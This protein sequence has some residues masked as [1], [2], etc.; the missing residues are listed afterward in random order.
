MN[1]RVKL[2]SW[3]LASL[4]VLLAT[5]VFGAPVASAKIVHEEV[6]S[7]EVEGFA[8]DI[9]A[10]RSGGPSNGDVYTADYPANAVVKFSSTGT[11][12]ATITGTETPAGSFGFVNFNTFTFSGIAIDSSGSVNKGDLYAAD[13][14]HNVV[15]KFDQTGKF[16]C[17]ITA[18]TPVSSEEQEHECNG[19]AGSAPTA[20]SFEPVAA[21][22]NGAGDLF[23]ADA[24][25]KAVDEFGPK[26]EFIKEITGPD[27]TEPTKLALAPSGALYIA[28]G[29]NIFS[30]GS[31]VVKDSGGTFAVV[32]SSE[33][34]G[35]AVDPT[36]EYLYA[37]DNSAE[38]AGV[39]RIDEY[40]P[41]GLLLGTFIS[42]GYHNAGTLAVGA[43]G[44]VYDAARES[45]TIFGPDI[46]VPTVTVAAATGV[47]ETT[48]TFHGEVSPDSA[49]GGTEVLKCE[50]EYVT[51]AQFEASQF[52]KPA[53]AECAPATPYAS[54][55]SVS[56]TISGLAPSTTYHY[57]LA[58]ASANKHVSYSEAPAE[59]T[60]ATPGPPTIAGET[61]SGITRT[62]ATLEAQVN[63]NGHDTHYEFQYGETESYGESVPIAAPENIG[64]GQAPVPV[65]QQIA[66]LKIGTTYHYRVVAENARG[67]VTGT[68]HTV[69]TVPVAGV[70][71]Q[72]VLAGPHT[73]TI[74]ARIDPKMGLPSLNGTTTCV[75]QY[76]TE[77]E[78]AASGFT[79]AS[80]LPCTP[81]SIESA[82]EGENVI[83][84]L[85]GLALDTVYDYRFVTVNEAGE[86]TV[87]GTLATFGLVP[88][89]EAGMFDTTGA[90]Y[91]QAG[92]HPYELTTNITFNSTTDGSSF[93]PASGSLKDVR[94][95]LPMGLVGNPT[96]AAK[97][98]VLIADR[99]RAPQCGPGTQVGVMHVFL[100]DGSGS[101]LDH[102]LPL[103]NVVPGKGVAAEFASSEIAAGLNATIVARVRTG[104]GYGVS[105]DSLNIPIIGTVRK[106]SVTIWG[107]PGDPAHNPQRICGCGSGESLKAFLRA[108]TSCPG[109]NLTTNVLADSYNAP[110]EFAEAHAEMPGTTNC[111]VLPF[112]PSLSVQP[113]SSAADS[114]TGL[115]FDLH[116]PQNNDP[117]GVS[118]ADLKNA[119]VTFPAGLSVNPSAADGLGACSEGQVGFTGFAELNKAS[120]PGVQTAQFTPG[121]AQCPDSSKLGDVELDTPL[122]G[123][124]L[125]GSLYLA[126]QGANPFGSMIAVYLTVDD[127]VSG[128]I[129][130][131]PGLVQ[132]NPQTGQLT[133]TFEQNPQLPFEDLKV[134][135]FG[136]SSG[137][138]ASLTTPFTCGS[139]AT[140]TALR[141]WSS[142]EGKD[143]TPS[144]PPFQI[145]EAPGGGA[146]ASSEGQTPNKPGFQAGTASPIGG[147]YSPFVLT[148]TREDGSQRF[149]SLNVT[150]P[151]GLTGKIA[152]I[153]QCPQADIEKAQ[154]RSHEGEGASE[155]S[156]PSCPSGSEVG[157]VHVGAGSGAPFYV[158]GRAYFA[159]GYEG[160]PFSLVIV[161]P[162]VAG[163]FD[164]GTVV[165]RAGLFIDPSTAQVTVKSDPFPSILDGIPLDIRSVAVDMSRPGFTLNPTSC[166][167]MA[168]TGE[169]TSTAG[170]TAG[171][172]DRFQA[173]G[174]TNL[175][176]SPSFTA[177]TQG[178]A[179]RA[180]GAS[181]VVKVDPLPGQANIAK[182]DLQLPKQLPSRLK[183]LQKA[184]TQAQFAANPAGCPEG[185]DIGRAVVHTPILNSPLAGPVYLVAHG[186]AA[187][188]DVEMVL[189]GEGVVIVL[190][191]QTQIKN[192]VTYSHFDAV[193]DAPI[194]S[195]EAVL[196]E[197]P[198]SV[199]G[200][201]IPAS[202]K[203]S[204]CGQSMRMP[205]TI[206]GQNGAVVTQNTRIGI[207]G[208][209]LTRPKVVKKALTR[210]QKLKAALKACRK[211]DRGKA[212]RRKRETCEKAGR[213]K[214]GPVKKANKS[215]GKKK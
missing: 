59:E 21:A 201:N 162:A 115:H 141:P 110:G 175:P 60:F 32:D 45:V 166:D 104:E 152:G 149:G 2:H 7:F 137:S 91:T 49:H 206:T 61:A 163:P 140:S 70:Q 126:R 55:Q 207:T 180:D 130:K 139:Y 89:V 202:A 114:P 183:T 12:L 109:G 143:E 35:V 203:F 144:S 215:H 138:R 118:T 174:C 133:A 14:E 8:L 52:A 204:L 81:A 39:G 75:F 77:A 54:A 100:E 120:E 9:A 25:H 148:L 210:A 98:T 194:S 200:T 159:G 122:L 10:D 58:A 79:A 96:A 190:D 101:L 136:G 199:F 124:P 127:P 3:T 134:K 4:L 170:Q 83:V 30:G 17:Q 53:M 198:H 160:A 6:G 205:T 50:F 51:Q 167:T 82:S 195:F 158:T 154:S 191:G 102:A 65:S 119:T 92:G 11:P 73:A 196:P 155:Q 169:E 128:V 123:H 197:G 48:A 132:A 63:P 192:G 46:A 57:R 94:V 157:T 193:P 113:E 22:V 80:S 74:K 209:P 78:F 72:L 27:I 71:L 153:E 69:M 173:G 47:E 146:C 108:P 16:I 33:P 212:K 188:P 176:F 164:L 87:A 142:P 31:D 177:G 19:A 181:L 88:P 95:Q 68:D 208:C 67:R 86:G 29:G 84:Q 23:V 97:C 5:F 1:N 161:T 135:L 121:A 151:P 125:P 13:I 168:V 131:L 156:N 178:K 145:A 42:N 213:K 66:G 40:D 179:S 76:V 111:A 107:V 150:L 214:Y 185:S 105:A 116:V 103:F 43:A 172:S 38:G 85:S 44:Q 182:V 64:E 184:C 20:G 28:N 106:V 15:D 90:P 171:V 186:G 165:V 62:E 99:N 189:Q 36:T 129:V 24:T 93:K 37:Q 18:K 187:F 41:T 211:N 56:A 147:S 117:A 112:A 34:R 26:G